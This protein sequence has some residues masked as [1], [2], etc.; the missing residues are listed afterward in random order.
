M[1]GDKAPVIIIKKKKGGDHGAHGGAWKVAY[2]DFVTA[3]MAFF[4][5]MWLLGSDE[6]VKEAVADYFNNPTSAWRP[7]LQ[8]PKQA[9][10]GQMTGS[11]DSLLA[12]ATGAVPEDLV[13]RP[14]QPNVEEPAGTPKLGEEGQG[15]A[16]DVSPPGE[17]QIEVMRFAVPEDALFERG[18][19][20]L[21]A[22]AGRILGQ[23]STFL[24]QFKGGVTV[25][26]FLSPDP[27]AVQGDAYEFAMARAVALAD[28]IV[29]RGWVDRQAAS[30]SVL[31]QPS[32][33]PA[34]GATRRQIELTFG[35]E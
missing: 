16:N 13:E 24:R 31:D 34:T 11:G 9:P 21:T 1:A 23:Y 15:L 17:L 22:A 30:S 20:K 8:N 18:A 5:V 35:R 33:S 14:S 25:T 2:A 12:G 28:Y 6:E 7:D 26:A 32:R 19:A 10:L 4:L 27:G 29:E 3:M